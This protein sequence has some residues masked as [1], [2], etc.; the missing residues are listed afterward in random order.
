MSEAVS[1]PFFRMTENDSNGHEQPSS[2]TTI[3]YEEL[4][5]TSDDMGRQVI[6]DGIVVVENHQHPIT[7]PTHQ[8]ASKRMTTTTMATTTNTRTS[9]RQ[10][11][12]TRLVTVTP[13]GSAVPAVID[14]VV[15]P[16]SSVPTPTQQHKP[17]GRPKSTPTSKNADGDREFES[18]WIC[19]G[20]REAECMMK[21]E[22]DQ[23]LICE[24]VCRRL[25]HYPCAGLETLPTDDEPYIC[26]DCIQK[27]HVC[28]ICN[29]YGEDDVDVFACKS[30]KCGLFFHES[31][32]E[33]QNVEV[34]IVQDQ[35]VTDDEDRSK[36]KRL[37][38][39]PAHSCW[40]CNQTE[41][42]EAD[43]TAEP[44]DKERDGRKSG[45]GRKKR[46]RVSNTVFAPKNEITLVVRR[47]F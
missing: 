26:D 4:A 29:A 33:M 10:T 11:R 39:C 46:K 22:A 1:V 14:G 23:L 31:C 7:P 27:K 47:H 40:T 42:L 18:R 21:P 28:C 9:G 24:G 37:F 20:C 6:Q 19:S 45:K 8:D 36:G 15:S 13:H 38:L 35:S 41:L 17:R 3:S 34:H 2:T 16:P 43:A 32:L 30:S 25:F 44:E 5:V 12:K